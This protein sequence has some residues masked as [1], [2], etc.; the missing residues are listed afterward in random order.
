MFTMG[1]MLD[2]IYS[3]QIIYLS[4][5]FSGQRATHNTYFYLTNNHLLE[6]KGRYFK[7]RSNII[8]L[9]LLTKL[10]ILYLSI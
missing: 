5:S 6:R 10:S 1:R 9:I 7:E 8:L 2:L 3:I 4:F